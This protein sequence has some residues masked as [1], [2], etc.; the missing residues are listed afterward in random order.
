MP[1]C[2]RTWVSGTD[3]M[4]GASVQLRLK[5]VVTLPPSVFFWRVNVRFLPLA[6]N[7]LERR[8]DEPDDGR[9]ARAAAEGQGH[10]AADGH[11]HRRHGG[12]WAGR[13]GLSRSN[14]AAA[15]GLLVLIDLPGVIVWILL[16][17]WR[18]TVYGM[19]NSFLSK[20]DARSIW[21]ADLMKTVFGCQFCSMWDALPFDDLVV[22]RVEAGLATTRTSPFVL[23]WPLW[24]EPV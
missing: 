12:V 6:P 7:K 21:W 8:V 19:C 15:G 2:V 13:A 23:C 18:Y 11:L 4:R 20:R 17:V 16:A 22:V 10:A 1:L 5:D 14:T 3:T 24:F 9:G